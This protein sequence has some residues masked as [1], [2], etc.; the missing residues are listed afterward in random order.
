[1][2]SAV[3]DVDPGTAEKRIE[4]GEGNGYRALNRQ[5]EIILG[6]VGTLG[7]ITNLVRQARWLPL[8]F[9]VHL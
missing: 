6:G 5:E 9:I 1:M 4:K 8:S 2:M 3:A 7:G